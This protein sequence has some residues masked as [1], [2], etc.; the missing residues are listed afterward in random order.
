MNDIRYNLGVTA[1]NYHGPFGSFRGV[2]R[3]G[4][5]EKIDASTLFGAGE[6]KFLRA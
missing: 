6:E 1:C 3:N 4:T 2:I 5:G